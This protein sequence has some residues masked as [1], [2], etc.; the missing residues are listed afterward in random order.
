MTQLSVSQ[1]TSTKLE[2][3]W[4]QR[5]WGAGGRDIKHG[6]GVISPGEIQT[7]QKD[8]GVCVCSDGI[9]PSLSFFLLLLHLFLLLHL[10]CSYCQMSDLSDY[11]N[12]NWCVDIYSNA[13]LH[14]QFKCSLPKGVWA[15]FICIQNVN[16]NR[17]W[18]CLFTRFK[19]WMRETDCE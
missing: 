13:I 18:N 1:E 8:E 11:F 16:Q 19:L 15:I 14:L 6:Q 4:G 7:F 10:Y 5:V 2:L 3:V 12:T 9:L 17:N